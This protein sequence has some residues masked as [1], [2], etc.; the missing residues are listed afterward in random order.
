[1]I[2]WRFLLFTAAVGLLVYLHF[3]LAHRQW[4]RLKGEPSTEIDPS[5]IRVENYFSQSFRAKVKEWLKLPGAWS[6]D[7]K[8]LFIAKG[9]ERIRVTGPLQMDA[10]SE[11]AEIL[12]VRGEFGCGKDCRL[13]SEILARG[14]ARIGAGSQVQAITADGNLV[15]E[16]SVH[17]ARWADSMGEMVLD[18]GCL[19]GARATS[20]TAI[21]LGP[22]ARAGSVY[23]PAITSA[24]WDGLIPATESAPPAEEPIELPRP[25]VGLEPPVELTR[26]GLDLK[27]LH[28]LSPDT[29]LYNGDWKTSLAIHSRAKL[30]VKG[31][32]RMACHS[33]L[34]QDVKAGH[35]LHLEASSVARGSLVAG[36]NLVLGEGCRFNGVLHAGHSILLSRGVRGVAVDLPVAAYAVEHLHVEDNV[37]VQGKL[38]GGMG[39]EVAEGEAQAAV[40]ERLE[41]RKEVRV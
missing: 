11:S 17:V 16:N 41:V 15:L 3:Y 18:A 33:I 13:C 14:N 10:G 38:A 37:A 39:V 9:N 24:N 20:R 35:S 21:R 25:E 19:I 36:R 4:R 28:V 7:K 5:Y 2:P 32:C 22:G 12:V 6:E 26:A 31:D 1:M 23:A 29:W 40:R 30:V 34:D 27:K 8:D